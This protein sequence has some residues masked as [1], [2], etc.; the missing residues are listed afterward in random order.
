[1]NDGVYAL[2]V[3]ALFSSVQITRKS[4]NS[5]RTC[6]L[7]SVLAEAV[8]STP[9]VIAI[10]D[11]SSVDLTREYDAN[12]RDDT[13][14]RPIR[15]TSAWPPFQVCRYQK[16]GVAQTMTISAELSNTTGHVLSFPS[17]TTSVGSSQHRTTLPSHISQDLDQTCFTPT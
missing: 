9:S 2:N 15:K 6:H 17:F 10:K 12:P 8:F 16:F 13:S 14:Y 3:F 1:M 11:A 5:R 4:V 7:A